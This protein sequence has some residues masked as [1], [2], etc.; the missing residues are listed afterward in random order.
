MDR[1][2]FVGL[3]A[4]GAPM[5]WNVHDAGYDLGVFNRSSGPVEPFAEAGIDTYES[6]AAVA[7]ESDAVVLMVTG[8]EALHAVTVGE[9]GVATGLAPGTAVVN[10]STVSTEA[11]A[12]AAAGVEEAGGD[13]VDAPVLGTVAPAEAGELLV[14]AGADD[15]VYRRVEP[16]LEVFGE[17]KHVGGVGDGTSAKLTSNLLLGVMM[18]GFSEA[19]AFAES[20]GLDLDVVLDFVQDG[21]LGAPLFDYKGPVV[22]ERDFSPQFPVDLLF[23]DLNLV[24]E[25]AGATATPL[26]ATAASREAASATRA[27][28][29]GEE[30]MMALVKHL[31]DVTGRTVG[32]D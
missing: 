1:I 28:G 19:L 5:A 12:D 2:G 11:T 10:A 21:A 23:K 15:D 14:L 3:G 20:Q 27:L 32:E 18:E 31:E 4:M 24:L 29:Y 9:E 30:D 7:A 8:P 17:V 26:P 13:F 22:A 6:P 25:E 16:L